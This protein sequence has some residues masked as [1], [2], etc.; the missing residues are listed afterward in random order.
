VRT[1]LWEASV[2][3]LANPSTAKRRG[4]WLSIIR[5]LL[6]EV[7]VLILLS[8]AIVGYLKWSSDSAW[9][10]FNAVGK[11]TTPAPKTPIQTVRGQTPCYRRA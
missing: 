5:T 10:E 7:F 2:L 3:S 11:L 8:G 1:L 9:A 4:F 6:V